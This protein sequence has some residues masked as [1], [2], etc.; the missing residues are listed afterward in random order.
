VFERVDMFNDELETAHA[1][2]RKPELPGDVRARARY[3]GVATQHRIH[4]ALRAFLNDA[5]KKTHKITFNPIYAV[6]L[7]SEVREPALVWEPNRSPSSSP[8]PPTTD[9]TSCGGSPCCAASAAANWPGS[10]TTTSTSTPAPS[11]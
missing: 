11:P 5:W 3:T 2:G 7:E 10:A 4:A 9:C 8:T 6:E 1:A